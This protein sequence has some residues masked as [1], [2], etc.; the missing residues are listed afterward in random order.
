MD[1]LFNYRSRHF[2]KPTAKGI[3]PHRKFT[4]QKANRLS[5]YVPEPRAF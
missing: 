4:K 2:Y 1:V 3:L 5:S